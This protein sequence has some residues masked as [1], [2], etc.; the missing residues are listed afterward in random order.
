MP[1]AGSNLEM[2]KATSDKGVIAS[3]PDGTFEQDFLP[4]NQEPHSP[5][6]LSVKKL[7]SDLYFFPPG[8]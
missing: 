4:T 3:N 8:S 1:A 6:A 7:T 2:P 5:L